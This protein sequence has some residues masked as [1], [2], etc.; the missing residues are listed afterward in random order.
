MSVR[1]Q[2]G[3]NGQYGLLR[4][5]VFPP[6]SSPSQSARDVRGKVILI[7][8]RNPITITVIESA[9]GEDIC[10]VCYL[11]PIIDWN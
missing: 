1:E 7:G 9:R 10:F 3:T 11:G 2:K 8:A 6:T 5:N 4:D